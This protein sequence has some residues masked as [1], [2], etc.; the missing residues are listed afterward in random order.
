MWSTSSRRS[1]F[2]EVK[3]A[4][5]SLVLLGGTVADSGSR[6]VLERSRAT[7]ADFAEYE[8]MV[9]RDEEG[10]S[11]DGWAAE[12]HR[13]HMHRIENPWR[14][15][16]SN[17]ETGE[18]YSYEVSS[19]RVDQWTDKTNAICGISDR[20]G[21]ESLVGF[22]SL[23]DAAFGPLDTIRISDARLTRTYQVNPQ[24]AL[25]RVDWFSTDGSRY[26][27]FIQHPVAYSANL[28]AQ[29]IFSVESLSKIVTPEQY[30]QVPKSVPPIGPSDKQCG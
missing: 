28:P 21:I 1:G 9:E 8:W 11:Q 20:T 24:G 10:V 7:T 5:L 30:Q 19:G 22:P 23:T 6:E 25:I 16:I 4:L 13:G 15:V 3:T 14:R 17:C 27:C 18:T 2:I 29:D 12:Y 26:P